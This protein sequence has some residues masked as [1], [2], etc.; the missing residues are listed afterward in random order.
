MKQQIVL[1][2]DSDKELRDLIDR[3][4][5]AN[6]AAIEAKANYD[7]VKKAIQ[8]LLGDT[9]IVYDEDGVEILTWKYGKDTMKFQQQEFKET[10]PDLYKEFCAPTRGNRNFKPK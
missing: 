1:D 5:R 7:A 6:R 3:A 4:R 10:Y 8:Q 2:K 9:E